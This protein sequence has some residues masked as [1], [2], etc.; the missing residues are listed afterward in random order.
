LQC[1]EAFEH[2]SE[3]YFTLQ[4]SKR[5]AQAEMDT[6]RKGKVP[7]GISSDVEALWIGKLVLVAVN[8]GEHLL[9]VSVLAFLFSLLLARFLAIVMRRV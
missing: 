2:G 4:P 7:I 5:S 3:C 8:R 9:L 1:G 6:I